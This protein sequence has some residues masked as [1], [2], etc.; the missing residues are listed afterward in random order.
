MKNVINMTIA[1]ITTTII[2]VQP[3]DFL[4]IFPLSNPY[5]P[6]KAI[7]IPILCPKFWLIWFKIPIY[8]VNNFG[9][10]IIFPL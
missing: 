3:F 7:T 10:D 8:Y 2:N 4:V 6:N 1:V 9:H 5:I